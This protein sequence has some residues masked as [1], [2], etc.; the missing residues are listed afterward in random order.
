MKYWLMSRKA[1]N[2]L[3]LEVLAVQS[4]FTERRTLRVVT[5]SDYSDE[6][7]SFSGPNELGKTL[8]MRAIAGRLKLDS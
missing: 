5:L 4:T 8:L 6:I 1:I 3:I 2:T 7:I